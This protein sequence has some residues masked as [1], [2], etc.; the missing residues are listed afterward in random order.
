M[1][2]VKDGELEEEEIESSLVDTVPS[3]ITPPPSKSQLAK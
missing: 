1:N 2:D 3:I